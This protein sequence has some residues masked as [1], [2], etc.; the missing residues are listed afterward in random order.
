MP[1]VVV[2]LPASG[3]VLVTAPTGVAA[4]VVQ[5]QTLHSNPGPGIPNGTTAAFG[6]M[7]SD[8][9]RKVLAQMECLVIDEIS[10]VD[11]E[12]L[13]WWAA[14]LPHPVQLILCGDFSQL[15]PVPD[16]QQSLDSDGFLRRCVAAARRQ[17]A[18]ERQDQ[19]GG[20]DGDAAREAAG[21]MDPSNDDDHWLD[22]QHNTPFG[23]RETSGA[24]AFRSR[25]WRAADLF[26]AHLQR[27]HRT[28]EPVLLDALADMRAGRG[29]SLRVSA[30]LAAT[31]RP[32]PSLEGV[33]PTV[34]YPRRD[35]VSKLNTDRLRMLN[36]ATA[37]VYE[38]M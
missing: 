18:P 15:P 22:M 32:L 19:P 5:G 29:D 13:D 7:H 23:V 31:S 16:K 33:E 11:A 17:D 30:L 12:F 25:L 3:N 34:L 8:S 1:P 35:D 36:P 26:V 21:A 37:R 2:S 20:P 10:M 14:Q 6:N 9:R 24:Y 28:R 38:A 27:V 4:L